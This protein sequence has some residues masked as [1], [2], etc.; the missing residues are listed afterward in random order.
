MRRW[1]SFALSLSG[2]PY[3]AAYDCMASLTCSAVWA[4]GGPCRW[5][6]R[7]Y[8]PVEKVPEESVA[9]PA[10]RS[11]C[12]LP[13]FRVMDRI[14]IVQAPVRMGPEQ[15]SETLDEVGGAAFAPQAVEVAQ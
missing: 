15:V 7:V 5:S 1:S 9:L 14:A 10:T 13:P 8:F 3:D 11:L 2:L 6:L 4:T 12:G